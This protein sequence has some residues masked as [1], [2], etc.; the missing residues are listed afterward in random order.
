[1]P[2]SVLRRSQGG[3]WWVA[4]FTFTH[5]FMNGW[6][7]R[8]LPTL[9]ATPPERGERGPGELREFFKPRTILAVSGGGH[10]PRLKEWKNSNV[11]V[12]NLAKPT[13]TA[14]FLIFALVTAFFLI[15]F[16]V[17]E[18]FLS[19]LVPTL[20]FGSLRAA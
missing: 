16:V 15:F 11:K 19:C 12:T 2:S 14:F 8:G 7:A 3:R 5:R 18:F 4:P 17:T 9:G 6:L 20:F 10:G 1:M 13:V